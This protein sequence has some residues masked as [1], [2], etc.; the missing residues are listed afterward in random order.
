MKR[1]GGVIL[2]L[3]LVG[4]SISAFAQAQPPGSYQQSCRDIRVQGRTLTAVC[5]GDEGRARETSLD[6]SRC[7]GDIGNDNGRLQ[8]NGGQAVA[9]NS[10]PSGYAGPGYAAPGY[11]PSG[12][13][14]R[15]YGQGGDYHEHCEALRREAHDV[16]ERLEHTRYGE[17]R[18]HLEHR[19]REINYQRQDCPHH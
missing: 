18:E 19:L 8:C 13:P 10:G 14:A 2:A 16:Y 15:R 3:A 12:Y 17:D 1:I 5:R 4:L 9:Q 7:V 6:I 11:P